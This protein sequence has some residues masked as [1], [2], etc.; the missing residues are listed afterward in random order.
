MKQKAKY[1][2]NCLLDSA[3][4]LRAGGETGEARHA[5]REEIGHGADLIKVYADWNHLTLTVG[6]ADFAGNCPEQCL[7]PFDRRLT[8]LPSTCRYA[9]LDVHIRVKR[10]NIFGPPGNPRREVRRRSFLRI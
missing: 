6:D 3:N 4:H 1:S 2:Y 10:R 5:V 7:Y 8:G 9:S